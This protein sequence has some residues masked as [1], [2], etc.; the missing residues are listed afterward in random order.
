MQLE[1]MGVPANSPET[2]HPFPSSLMMHTMLT[3][4]TVVGAGVSG[5]NTGFVGGLPR[6]LP[7]SSSGRIGALFAVRSSGREGVYKGQ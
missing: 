5:K 7:E 3:L 1:R 6:N 2:S 4:L